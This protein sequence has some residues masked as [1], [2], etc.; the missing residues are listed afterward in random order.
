M[1]ERYQVISESFLEYISPMKG[2][3]RD[4]TLRQV[5]ALDFFSPVFSEDFITFIL[6]QEVQAVSTNK[7]H[8]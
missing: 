2:R 5:T 8:L 1:S 3:G 7:V 6:T 4:R